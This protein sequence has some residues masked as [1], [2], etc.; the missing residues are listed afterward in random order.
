[1]SAKSAPPRRL[2]GRTALVTGATRGIGRAVAMALAREGAHL[3][4]TGRT[5]GALEEVDDEV[6]AVTKAA[7]G[8]AESATLITLN[9]KHSEK[10]D[11]LGPTLF[12]RFQKLDILIANAGVLGTLSPL[13]HLTNDAF[14]E[15]LDIN[16]TA[17]WRL[18]RTL[19]PLLQKSDAGRA[20]FVTS[21]AA[22]AKN[23]YWGPYAV[24][25]AGL[26][27]L[28]KTYAL[29]CASTNVKANLI[30]PGPIRTRMRAKAFPGED[31]M[32]LKS[33]EDIAPAFLRFALPNC[34]ENGAIFDFATG[35][36]R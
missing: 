34:S 12:N 32:T 17:N 6:R 23:A 14:L 10:I 1:M 9:L 21:G 22:A 31:P 33:P 29:E 11:A 8:T 20:V 15:T 35:K 27:A 30:N 19:D 16:L 3:I 4:L 25:K 26:E 2:E 7:T 5:S 36:V 13:T 18:I 24:S 28:V